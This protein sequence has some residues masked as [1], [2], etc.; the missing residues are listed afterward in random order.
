MSE[1]DQEI[2]TRLRRSY[3]AFNRGDFDAASEL[4]HPKIEFVRPGGQ[5][6]LRGAEA[7]RAWME[8]DA[9]EE[10]VVEPLEFTVEGDKVLV[11]QHAR[12]R[13]AGSGIEMGL[14][15]WAVWTVDDDGLMTRLEF[16]LHHQ[17][18]EARKAAGLRE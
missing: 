18:T 17:E 6:S 8:P 11:R 2:I 3:E 14:D 1:R 5:S 12:A 13:G 4:A 15:S 10:Q 9:F 16:Y 7:L